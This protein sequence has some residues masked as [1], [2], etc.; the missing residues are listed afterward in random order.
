M[1]YCHPFVRGPSVQSE[2]LLFYVQFSTFVKLKIQDDQADN[3]HLLF[4]Q[5]S[6][7]A[8]VRNRSVTGA[9]LARNST[10]NEY[11][12]SAFSPTKVDVKVQTRMDPRTSSIDK[13]HMFNDDPSTSQPHTTFPFVSSSAN[14]KRP[15]C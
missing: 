8:A 1:R 7:T 3:T 5:S 12:V 11:A 9:V 2:D 15:N 13:I 4:A 6:L 10:P 14:V